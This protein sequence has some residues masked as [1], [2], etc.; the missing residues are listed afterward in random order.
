MSLPQTTIDAA[1][2]IGYEGQLATG[3]S[4]DTFA[5]KNASGAGIPFGRFLIVDTGTVE[6]M[7]LP[8]SLSDTIKAVSLYEPAIEQDAN[9]LRQYADKSVMA[10]TKFGTVIMIPEQDVVPGDPVYARVTVDGVDATKS[11]GRLRKDSAGASAGTKQK[12]TLTLSGALDGGRARSQKLVLDADLVAADSIDGA[13]AGH[14]IATV[15]YATSHNVTMDLLVKAIKDVCDANALPYEDIRYGG[16]S[17]R[18]IHITGLVPSATDLALTAFAVTHGGLGT[19]VFASAT[20]A[21]I[22]A[23]KAP[24]ELQARLHGDTLYKQAWAGNHDDTVALFAAQLDGDA[25]VGSAV[26]TVVPGSEDL[27]ITLEAAAVGVNPIA[28]DQNQVNNGVTARTLTKNET[29]AV[30]AAAVAGKAIAVPSAEIMTSAL[31]GK[32]CWVRLNL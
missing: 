4:H 14:A 29:V 9:G 22:V 3:G 7:K 24:H 18:E 11:P 23:G 2:A 28:I 31:A 8:S 13:I 19:A 5:R 10:C 21:D 26:V 15:T 30:G 16:A 32:P 12:S 6:A 20:G 27:V 25:Q 17:N 1:P